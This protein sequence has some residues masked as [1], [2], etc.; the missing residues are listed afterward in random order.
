[1]F[2]NCWC[3]ECLCDKT[4][5]VLTKSLK[6]ASVLRWNVTEGEVMVTRYEKTVSRDE[7]RYV[8]QQQ[9]VSGLFDYSTGRVVAI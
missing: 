4:L 1:M 2:K 3:S 8:T 7:G 9:K 5:T 6:F